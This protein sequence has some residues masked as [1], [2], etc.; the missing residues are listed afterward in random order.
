MFWGLCLLAKIGRPFY[1]TCPTE[2]PSSK[3]RLGQMKAWQKYFCIFSVY[4]C[5]FSGLAYL[6]YLELV[7]AYSIN[8]AR[9]LL[10]IHGASSILFTLTIGS[11]LTIHIY[12]GWIA[13]INIWTGLLQL[14]CSI[15]IICSGLFLYYGPESYRLNIVFLHWLF[16][17]FF[18]II[19]SIHLISKK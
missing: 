18:L 9:F 5:S 7:L 16:G 11:I 13:R 10:V 3:I 17:I 1:L 14:A 8:Q 6:I 19:F 15:F 2:M 4:L 12:T